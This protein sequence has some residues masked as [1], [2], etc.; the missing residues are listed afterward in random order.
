[1]GFHGGE[2]GFE[3][4]AFIRPRVRGRVLGEKLVAN[5]GKD[6]LQ[7]GFASKG[8]RFEEREII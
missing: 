2:R 7:A 8:E 4:G 6:Y 3:K 5:K 1:M